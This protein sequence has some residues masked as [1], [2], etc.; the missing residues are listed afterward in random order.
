MEKV[1]RAVSGFFKDVKE[2]YS[3]KRIVVWLAIELVLIGVIILID[4]FTKLYI[5]QPIADGSGDIVLIKGVLRFTAVRNTGASF[6]IFKDSTFA[7]AMVSLT[8][9]IVLFF[10]WILTPKIRSF[11]YRGAVVCIIGGGI[12]NFIDRITLGYVR[13]FVYFELID[14]A[15]FNL[16]D[17][18]LTIGTTLLIIYVLL[19]FKTEINDK[20]T[21]NENTRDTSGTGDEDDNGS[22]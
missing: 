14:F 7:L 16:A 9:V 12:G 11:W 21:V 18:A 4:Y 15:V 17:S 5:Y 2:G 19:S 22:F 10:V 8:T 20:K 1:K 6:G 3:N 13:D